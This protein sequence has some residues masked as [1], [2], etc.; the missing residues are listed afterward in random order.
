MRLRRREW[1][2]SD[3]A[4][5]SYRIRRLAELRAAVAGRI[6]SRESIEAIR[7]ALTTLF[8]GFDLKE[9]DDDDAPEVAHMDRTPA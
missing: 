4:Q 7:A 6:D 8:E 5:G 2:V 3:G 1:D 9:W